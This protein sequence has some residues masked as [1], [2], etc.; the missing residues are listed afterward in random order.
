MIGSAEEFVRLR[1]STDE[2]EYR[3][4][5]HDEASVAVW[6]DVI[7]RYP[8]MKAWVAHNKTVPSVILDLL[9]R[10]ADADV[11]ATVADKR[12]LTAEQFEL[13]SRDQDPMVRGRIA[14]NHKAPV[15]V[16]Q[17]LA[18]DS[19]PIVREPAQEALSRLGS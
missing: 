16:L 7:A 2:D 8:H 14:Y 4:A 3:R 17:H 9:A 6:Q 5:A 10:D 11:R 18:K 12:K 15:S 13:L 1:T 19:E